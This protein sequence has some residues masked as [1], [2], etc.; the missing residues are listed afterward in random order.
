[1]E[2]LRCCKLKA[3]LK[4]HRVSPHTDGKYTVVLQIDVQAFGVC[5]EC[6]SYALSG[7]VWLNCH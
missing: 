6:V 5:F 7:D 3:A 2:I 1:M 4:N